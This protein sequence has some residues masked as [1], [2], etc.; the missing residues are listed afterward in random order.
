MNLRLL[1]TLQ[2]ARNRAHRAHGSHHHS[3]VANTTS[4]EKLVFHNAQKITSFYFSN[5]PTTDDTLVTLFGEQFGLEDNAL[6]SRLGTSLCKF[7]ICI[8]II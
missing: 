4:R 3:D 2:G 6:A 5:G 1:C 8:I 7:V